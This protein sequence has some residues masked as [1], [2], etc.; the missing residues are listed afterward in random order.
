MVALHPLLLEKGPVHQADALDDDID[1]GD[2]VHPVG[3]GNAQE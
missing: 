3:Q 2:D 1:D